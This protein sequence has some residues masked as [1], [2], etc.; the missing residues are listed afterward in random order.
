MNLEY[1]NYIKMLK[2]LKRENYKVSYQLFILYLTKYCNLQFIK[3]N[4]EGDDYYEIYSDLNSDDYDN[5]KLRRENE[6]KNKEA[7]NDN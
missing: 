7:N 3:I 1:D 5:Y 2:K 6:E 4:K